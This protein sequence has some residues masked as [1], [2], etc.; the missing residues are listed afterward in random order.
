[1][2]GYAWSAPAEC[3]MGYSVMLNLITTPNVLAHQSC[4]IT[5]V[6]RGCTLLVSYYISPFQAGKGYWQLTPLT[7][8][9]HTHT[10]VYIHNN[11]N[12]VCTYRLLR[13]CKLFLC[14]PRS[15]V[16]LFCACIILY[17]IQAANVY[18]L[19]IVAYPLCKPLGT[20]GAGT[21]AVH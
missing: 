6:F 19:Q 7:V 20:V 12:T 9:A 21:N 14:K 16:C 4:I 3:P 5:C 2:G 15:E 8:H 10:R 1:M 17:Y 11:W 13:V 18:N